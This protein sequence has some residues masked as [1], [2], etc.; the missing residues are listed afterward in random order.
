MQGQSVV[1]LPIR[2][3]AVDRRLRFALQASVVVSIMFAATSLGGLLV[4]SA[5]ARETPNW[6]VQAIGQDWFDLFV[7][8]PVIVFAA[9]WAARGSRRGQLLLAGVLLYAIYTF[10]IY[11]F[12]VHLNALFLVYCAGLGLALYA[13][14]ALAKVIDADAARMW[15]D[16]TMPRR[17]VS[18]F[19][20][21]IGV[22]FGLLWLMQLVPAALTGRDPQDL[23]E[24]GLLTNPIHVM[25][26]SFILPLHVLSGVLLWRRRPL[27]YVLAPAL[28]AFGGLM[29]ASIGFLAIMMEQHGVASGSLPVAVAM[30]VVAIVSL[31]LLATTL[32]SLRD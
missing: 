11:A 16:A 29:A 28:L 31:G 8:A 15:F 3:L 27:G 25:D 5:Y 18:G 12:A 7:A 17:V 22:A 1:E 26:L 4:S 9:L 23:V 32:R 20:L 13:L 14:I 6:A 21:F 10:A 19:L 30:M 24:T 2:S